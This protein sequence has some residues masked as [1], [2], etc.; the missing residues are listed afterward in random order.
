MV[1]FSGLRDINEA[2]GY[3]VG[4]C[5]HLDP[6][7]R[8]DVD[9]ALRLARLQPGESVLDLGTGS[10]RFIAAA[11]L[12]VESRYCVAVDAVEGFLRT[13]VPWTL[14]RHGLTVHPAGAVNE[15]VHLLH[16]DITDNNLNRTIRALVGAPSTFDCIVALHVFNTLPPHQ[17]RRVLI[18]LRRLLSLDGRLIT[19]MSARFTNIPAAPAEISCPIQFRVTDHT[20]SPG[21]H[22]VTVATTNNLVH[23]PNNGTAVPAR[24]VTFSLQV[25]P[26]RFWLIAAQQARHAAEDAGFSVECIHDIG[27][28]DSFDLPEHGHSPLQSTLDT[29]SMAAI[30]ADATK[31]SQDHTYSCAGRSFET[32]MHKL[33]PGWRQMSIDERDCHH[34]LGLQHRAGADL[35]QVQEANAFLPSGDIQYRTLEIGQVGVIIV[36]HKL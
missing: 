12:A 9:T 15:Q 23:V 22:V 2:F 5:D 34:V 14:E 13:D 35:A 8:P 26:N 7:R 4:Q 28:G 18:N 19:T 24:T 1:Y 11:K 36:L 16:A 29:M 33:T 20:E 27:K 3:M 31:S 21:S 25:A 10:G 6:A 32:M 30:L 17:R